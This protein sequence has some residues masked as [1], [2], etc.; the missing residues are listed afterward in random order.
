MSDYNYS[1]KNGNPTISD[2][3]LTCKCYRALAS[4]DY[5]PYCAA[6]GKF[7]NRNVCQIELD[8]VMRK[9]ENIWE[10]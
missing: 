10:Q 7:V 8:L 1:N 5:R 9:M 6:L 2:C 4:E 3:N